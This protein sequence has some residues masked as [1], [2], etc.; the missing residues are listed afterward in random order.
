MGKKEKLGN[1][2]LCCKMIII[3]E[4]IISTFNCKWWYEKNMYYK[5]VSVASIGAIYASDK[6]SHGYCLGGLFVHCEISN[7]M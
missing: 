2:G 3:W 5:Y 6:N 7:K 4:I 1:N